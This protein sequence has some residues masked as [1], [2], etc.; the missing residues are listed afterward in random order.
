MSKYLWPLWLCPILIFAL[1]ALRL[2]AQALDLA[3]RPV[4]RIRIDGLKQV[5]EQLVLN[6][7]RLKPGD[8]YDPQTLQQDIVRITH[9]GRFGSVTAQVEPQPDGSV[10]VIYQ[11]QE[12]PILA[13]VLTVGNKAISDQELLQLARL[14]AGDPIDPFLIDRAIQEMKRA[15]EKQ[16]YFQADI[17]PDKEILDEQ[18]VLIFRIREGP[19]ARLR[20]IRFQ[21]NHA[22]SD[23]QLLSKIRS[24]TYIPIFRKGQVDREQLE[25]DAAAL[26]DF[27]RD[28]GYL[29]A[30]V[31]RRLDISPDLKDATV[32]FTIYEGPLF[33]IDQIHVEGNQLFSRDQILE[34]MALKPGDVFNANKLR[35]SYDAII[36]LYGKLG[37]IETRVERAPGQPGIERL[38]HENQPKVDLL[39]RIIEGQPYTVGKIIVAGN[40]ASQDKLVLRQIRGLRPGRPFDRQGIDLTTKRLS[41]SPLFSSATVT[42]L[43]DPSQPQRDVLVE[44]KEKQTGS[45]SFGA[46]IS[47]D[48]GV[49]GAID[50]VQ[51]NF[52][53][54][55]WPESWGEFFT[56]RAFRGAGQVFSISIQPGTEYSRYAL[57][58]REP[59]LLESDYFLDTSLFFLDREREDYDESRLGASLGLGRRF[60]D[61]WSA[62]IRTRFENIDLS[63]IEP[64]APNDVFDLEGDHFL[65]TLGFGITRNT[66]DDPIFPTRGSVLDLSIARAGALGG[67]FDFT[68]LSIEYRKFWTLDEDFLGY[69]TILMLRTEIG[70]IFE[71]VSDVPVFERFYA[72]G[73]SFRGFAYRGVGPRG[74]IPG[75]DGIPHTPDDL[76]GDDPVGGNW[77]FL[78]SLEYSFPIYQDILRWVFFTDTGTVQKDFGFDDYRLSIGT[79]LRL[80]IPFLGQAPFA[81]DFAVPLL[82]EKGDD[83]RIVSFDLALPLR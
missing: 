45:L 19:A 83:T 6:Q 50:L 76:L 66:T 28:N 79:G 13:D 69:K 41:Q 36:D 18:G 48:L 62:S 78:L 75:P 21:G 5:P 11:V 51:R 39:V 23:R 14:R 64:D 38:F 7:V 25:Q 46:G 30:Q 77:L 37:F 9:L 55:D 40:S 16:G 44:V 53:I 31:G 74:L 59:S 61:V 29:D 58:F 68:R 81:L 54:A 27:Y 10:L 24:R 26:R 47:S 34:A 42:V 2:Q 52:D 80:K 33:T 67:D 82:K 70:Y 4:S 8:P 49:I 17:Q 60:G 65:T 73:R 1:P 35:K 43:G 20:A 22:F 71:D 15:Y 12:L 56:G 72:G 3:N 63:N 32:T 57:A